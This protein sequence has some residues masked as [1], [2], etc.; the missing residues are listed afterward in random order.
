M[1]GLTDDQVEKSRKQYG[2][3]RMTE[4]K[5]EGFLKRLLGN[6]K[7]PMI[8]ILC[9]ALGINFLFALLGETAWYEALGIAVAVLLA[10]F[11]STVSEHRNEHAFQK[12]QE[13]ASKILCKV[14]RNNT[15]VE[16]PI[17]EIVVDDWVLLQL[18]DK[19]PA[20]GIMRHGVI[21]V[22]QS[23]LNG[24][25]EEAEKI[26]LPDGDQEL[27]DSLDFLDPFQVFRGSVVCGGNG[28]MQVTTVGDTSIYGKLAGELQ[29]EERDSP[30]K[31]K[32]KDLAK[33]ISRFG[34]L[35]GI[36]IALAFL[37]QQVVV[38]NGFDLTVI[39]AYCSNGITLMADLLEA[40]M[41]AVI[42]IVMAVPEGLPLMIAIV[43]AQNMGKMLRDQV[44]VRKVTGIETAGSI[45]LL[46]SDKT[47]TITKGQLE[48]VAFLDGA[49]QSYAS[50]EQIALKLS[51]LLTLS[52]VYNNSAVRSK[53][54]D[55]TQSLIGGN[56]TERAMLEFVGP[57]TEEAATVL[58]RVPFSSANKYSLVTISTGKHAMTLVKGAPEKLLSYCSSFYTGEGE[59]KPLSQGQLEKLEAQIDD[60]AHRA[61]RVLVL[62]TSD[63]ERGEDSLTEGGWTLVGIVGIRDEVRP[64][65]VEAIA[66][67]QQAGI[68]VVMITGDRKDTATAIA[69]EAGILYKETDL[70]YTSD[71]LSQLSDEALKE[72]LPEIRVIARALPSDKS[73]LVR[74]AQEQNLVVGM[75]GDGV[76]DAPA[77]KR[78]D[79]GFAMGSGTEVAKEAGDIV[80]LNDNFQSVAKAILYGRTIFNSIRKFIV[81][82]LTINV[83]AVLISLIAPLLG[84]ESPLTITQI[85]WVNLVMDTLAA[86]AF[87]GEPT[88]D[89]YMKEKPRRRDESILSTNMKSAI[90]TGALWTLA[91]SLCLLLSPYAVQIFRGA[92]DDVYHMTG[93]F[94][95]FIFTA[96]FNA[97]NA[98]SEGR[99]LLDHLHKNQGFLKIMGMIVVIQ[100]LLTQMGGAIF[101]C[102]GLDSKEWLF[103]LVLAVLIIPI[104]LLRKT[105]MVK[106]E[107]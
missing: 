83:S 5:R 54:P 35:G 27:K 28:V 1:H 30:L 29:L 87:G 76:N 33:T 51:R 49:G 88:L 15:L 44:L 53:Q 98:R 11:V 40:V 63:E 58:T 46:L 86:M 75:T 6:F 56:A 92:T 101:R 41:L 90:L 62:A 103:V 97:F 45:N 43:S 19:I 95:F 100:V 39:S 21:Q 32:L 7:D 50:M 93:F 9:V 104:D 42:I 81:F 57:V 106:G 99:N 24:E 14:Y 77:L 61:I 67:V 102:H 23:A 64:E 36:I 52:V 94:T 22:D 8:R 13:E 26:A 47:G 107:N 65:A 59:T 25:A 31:V 91:V 37:F 80:I 68:Q 48:T 4:Q 60:L 72:K 3:N 34:Y 82:Q 12:L 78:A 74:L 38:Q 55:G 10:V 85:L 16:L 18:G 66:Q 71:E 70:I 96:I 2:S 89:R 20:D 105:I 17:D 73:R 79:V 69:K 84:M